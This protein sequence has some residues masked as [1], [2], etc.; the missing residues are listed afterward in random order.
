VAWNG[1]EALVSIIAGIIAG[2]VSLIGPGLDSIIEVASGA[3]DGRTSPKA[4][5]T[6]EPRRLKL[7]PK[8]LKNYI[9]DQCGYQGDCE[10]GGCKNISDSP[11]QAVLLALP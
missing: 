5:R 2:L 7:A 3:E 9:A 4:G 8:K 6:G 11:R 10:I 1:L